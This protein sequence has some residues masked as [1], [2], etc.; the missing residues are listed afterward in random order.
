MQDEAM[1]IRLRV[2]RDANPVEHHIGL[3]LGQTTQ[4]SG[5]ALIETRD[6]G[7]SCQVRWL[8]RY[9]PGIAYGDIAESVVGILSRPLVARRASDRSWYRPGLAVGI[10]AVG[11]TVGRLFEN[12]SASVRYVSLTA[13]DSET[14]EGQVHRVPKRELIGALQAALQQRQ[15]EVAA[16][17]PDAGALI[18][19]LRRYTTRI[20]LGEEGDEWRRESGRLDDLVNAL[21]LAYW[22]T[23]K[24]PA[25][26]HCT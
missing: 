18:E 9:P 1:F 14:R 10:T 7:A 11:K 26:A 8:R 17:L 23:Q 19:E 6:G 16:A 20:G 22:K 21:G 3:D 12:K 13:G 25:M 5:L 2:R 4:A 24:R 15:L